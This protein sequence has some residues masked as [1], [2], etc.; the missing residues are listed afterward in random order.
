M[1]YSHR[2][3]RELLIMN[4]LTK[5]ENP[6][7]FINTGKVRY[8]LLKPQTAKTNIKLFFLRDNIHKTFITVYCYNCSISLLGAIHLFLRPLLISVWILLVRQKDTGKPQI[9]TIH[10]FTFQTPPTAELGISWDLGTQSRSQEPSDL[11]HHQCLPWSALAGTQGW[12]QLLNVTQQRDVS[13]VPGI[14]TCRPKACPYWLIFKNT[15]TF[16]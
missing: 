1:L 12:S 4:N 13:I 11:C 5:K 7:P 2:V 8:F 9:A 3:L 15:N 10:R 16:D 6:F 14:L